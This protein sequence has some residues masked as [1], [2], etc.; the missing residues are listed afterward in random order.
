MTRPL[1]FRFLLLLLSLKLA[2]PLYSN[3]TVSSSATAAVDSSQKC[4]VTRLA[5]GPIDGRIAFSTAKMLE[6]YHYTHMKFDRGLSTKFF[7]HYL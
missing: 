7:D 5:P 2:L 6:D 1:V 3:E 4:N